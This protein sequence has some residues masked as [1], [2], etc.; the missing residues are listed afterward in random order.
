MRLRCLI[1]DDNASFRAAARLLLDRQGL[2]VVGV[3][4]TADAFLERVAKLRPDVVLV[5]VELGGESGFEVAQR[6]VDAGVDAPRVIFISTHPEQD[7]ADLVGASGAVGFLSKSRLSRQAIERL[8]TTRGPRRV[9]PDP[10][11]A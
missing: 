8:L 6:L 7:Y 9:A 2:H 4:A 1:V 10:P 3:A 5:D 11:S